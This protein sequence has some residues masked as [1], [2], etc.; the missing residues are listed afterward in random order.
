MRPDPNRVKPD[1]SRAEEAACER[2]RGRIEEHLEGYLAPLEEALDRGH[3]E[4][5]V[6]CGAELARLRALGRQLLELGPAGDE[7]R[8]AQTGLEARLSA[9]RAPHG[10]P[11]VL[12]GVSF[13]ALPLAAAA[14]GFLALVGLEASGVLS[15]PVPRIFETPGRMS[16]AWTPP[17]ASWPH[18]WSISGDPSRSGETGEGD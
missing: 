3:L 9:A 14:A 7:L 16:R 6:R 8:A 4:A 5:C 13:A 10:R 11:A 18:P 2:V 15:A 1:P 12:R 17:E